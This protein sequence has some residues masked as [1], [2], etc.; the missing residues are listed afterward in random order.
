ML[1][2]AGPVARG[3]VFRGTDRMSHP[4]PNAMDRRGFLQAGAVAAASALTLASGT[5]ADDRPAS[6]T[7]PSRRPLGKT[8]VDVTILT[9]GTWRAPGL[10]RLLRFSYANGVR[11]YDTAKSYG[12]EPDIA[13]WMQA[14]PEVRKN[15][16]L[17]TKD[18]PRDPSQMMGMLG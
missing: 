14:V 11:Y 3:R 6:K 15:I 10:D 1:N 12:S 13:K 5:K 17:V 8:G 7:T 4:E 16:F 9:Q 2:H 18:S